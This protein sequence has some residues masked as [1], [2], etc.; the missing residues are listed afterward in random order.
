MHEVDVIKSISI[1]IIAAMLLGFVAK[2][3]RQPL[4]L[5]YMVAGV[6][7]GKTQGLGWVATENIEAISELGLILLLF[8]IG[9]EIDLK[10]LKAAGKPVIASGVIQ[11]LACVGLGLAFFPF[12]GFGT[13]KKHAVLYLAVATALSS[14]M[15]VVKLLYDKFELDTVPGRITLG[16]LV[17]QDIWAILFLGVQGNLDHPEP[18]LILA[19]LAKAIGLVVVSLVASKY[20]LPLLFKSIA[21][22]PELM[23]IGALGWCFAVATVAAA[24]DLSREMGALIAGVS[25]ST[26]PYNLDVIAKII[27]LRD[28]FVTLFFVSLG[29]QIPRPDTS[30]MMLALATSGFLILSRFVTVF[31]V[32]RA[33]KL[34][35][36]ASLVPALNLAQVS[37]FALVIGAIGIKLG[38]IDEKVLSVLVFLLVITSVSSTY[39]ILYNHQIFL[40][41]NPL[42]RK[43]GIR[44][45]GDKE[46]EAKPIEAKPI[47]FLGFA[48]DASTVLHELLIKDPKYAKLTAVVDFNPEVKHEL[49][50]RGIECIY[51]DI[52]HADT[53]HHASIHEAKVLIS[54]IPDSILKG[55]SNA[56][57]L[58]QLGTMAP[59]SHVIVTAQRFAMARELYEDGASFV[60]VPRLMSAKELVEIV[61][62]ALEGDIDEHRRIATEMISSR[63]EVLP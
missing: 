25:I 58:R 19:S 23:M 26:F 9:L 3:L 55:T 20:I 41:L 39:M 16:V 52:S 6:L 4:I 47:I 35:N 40:A 61:E 11:F 36:R 29:T 49:D 42:L 27:S 5:G 50:K 31:P 37:E 46:A 2:W 51:G 14:T 38:H 30:L 45:L 34:G 17:F 15:I 62:D 32:L 22:L 10:K 44:D 18:L 56:R 21:K 24:L 1:A 54:T 60:Y 59:H 53:L 63:R 8:M 13:G 48:H 43:V 12:L 33:L 28:F 7:V 57:L